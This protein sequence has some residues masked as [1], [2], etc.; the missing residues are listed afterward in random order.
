[1]LQRYDDAIAARDTGPAEGID[2]DLVARVDEVL[3]DAVKDDPTLT[4]SPHRLRDFA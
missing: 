2:H 1:M 3:G 4:V